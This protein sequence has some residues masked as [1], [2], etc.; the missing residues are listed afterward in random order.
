MAI[1]GK[2]PSLYY[3]KNSSNKQRVI[4]TFQSIIT[5]RHEG[6]SQNI[7]KTLKVQSQKPSSAIMNLALRTRVTSA[8]EDKFIRVNSL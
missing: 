7:S 6:Q 5:L 1:F 4:I 8:A 3:G 2:R